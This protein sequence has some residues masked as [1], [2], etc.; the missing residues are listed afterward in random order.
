MRVAN[1][2]IRRG[3]AN[4]KYVLL[5]QLSYYVVTFFTSFLLPGVLGVVPNGYYQVYF[6]YTANFV[7]LM[8][9]GFNDGVLLKYGGYEYGDLPRPLFRT[10]M[11]MYA[12][13]SGIE[14]AAVLCV[15]LLEP[16]ADKR[17]AFMFVAFDI[18]VVN[19]SALLNYINQA[20]GRIKL[21]SFIVIAEKVQV[22]AGLCV[23]LALG[24]VDFRSAI[25]LDFAA[26]AVVLCINIYCSRELFFGKRLPWREAKGE[27]GDTIRVGVKLMIANLMAMLVLGA[28]K[29]VMERMGSVANF[30]QYAFATNATGV[31]MAFI[32]AVGLVLYPVLCRLDKQTLPYYYRRINR[33]LCAFIFSMM[34][35]YYPLAWGIRIF[36]P[37]YTPVLGYLYLLF[38]IVIMQSKMQLLINNYYES[39]RE[40]RAMMWANLSAVGLFAAVAVPLYLLHHSVL[41]IVWVTLGVF[42]WRCYASEIYLKRRM[43]VKEWRNIV[44]ELFMAALFI[45]GNGLLGAGWGFALYAAAVVVYLLRYRKELVPAVKTVLKSALGRVEAE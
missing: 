8:H 32:S 29:L 7:G 13:M 1:G 39:L 30:S 42:V 12:C 19:L 40:E 45:A 36:L 14:M 11:R 35:L 38:P 23:L 16:N 41:V 44:E 22:I 25:V 20:T 27:F 15:I 33:L 6:F 28:G 43:G 3:I 31:A 10:L 17:F 9:I 34:L 2:V 24:R 5:S 37:K 26:K 4:I 21:Y 18:V